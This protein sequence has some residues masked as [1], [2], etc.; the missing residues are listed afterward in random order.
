MT[1]QSG[2]ARDAAL[3]NITSAMKT[4]FSIIIAVL[5]LAGCLLLNSCNTVRGVGRDVEGVGGAIERVAR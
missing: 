5:T 1:L 2:L 3:T 4:K